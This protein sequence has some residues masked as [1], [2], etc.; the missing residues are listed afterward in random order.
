M[1]ILIACIGNIFKGDD[2]F[3][4]EVAQQLLQ[5]PAHE[6]VIV[7]DFGIRALD[8][9]Y[10]LMD[11]HDAVVVVDAAGRGEEPGTIT[12][13][14]PEIDAA[15]DA[16]VAAHDLDLSKV[17]Q[18]AAALGGPR[19]LLLACEPLDCG[20]EDGRMG[21]SAPVKAAIAPAIE[22]LDAI[23]SDL[24]SAVPEAA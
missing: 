24:Q 20:G 9:A 22:A 14:E 13:I 8:L 12:L 19:L 17:L 3:G 1:S 18:M 2:G 5:R 11:G 4:V 21:L 7:T 10:A 6:G 23:I 15:A 16:I